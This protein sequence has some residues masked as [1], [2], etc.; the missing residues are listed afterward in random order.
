MWPEEQS[1]VSAAIPDC[2]ALSLGSMEEEK[3]SSM[4]LYSCIIESIKKI[5]YVIFQI[6]RNNHHFTA[7]S[8]SMRQIKPLFNQN[9]PHGTM[10]Q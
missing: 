9:V 2:K 1:I 6:L 8:S 7:F 5:C 4:S 3:S 10:L